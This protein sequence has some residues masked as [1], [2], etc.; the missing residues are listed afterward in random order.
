MKPPDLASTRTGRKP[1]Q[2]G[3]NI[4]R[5]PC[6]RYTWR[7]PC[8]SLVSTLDWIAVALGESFHPRSMVSEAFSI[9]LKS[10]AALSAPCAPDLD[11]PD[12]SVEKIVLPS[13]P[14]TLSC[15]CSNPIRQDQ[16]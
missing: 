12:V 6:I 11:M 7:L 2:T 9:T 16:P 13:L 1:R 8:W 10:V 3:D 14:F 5:Q 15:T 4:C